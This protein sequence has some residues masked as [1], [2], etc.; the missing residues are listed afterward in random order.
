[1]TDDPGQPI[2]YK[3]RHRSDA[4]KAQPAARSKAQPAAGPVVQG[5][6]KQRGYLWFVAFFLVFLAVGFAL[7]FYARPIGKMV[8]EVYLSFKLKKSHL[9]GTEAAK[10]TKALTPLSTDPSKSVNTLLMGV[11]VGSGGATMTHCNSDTMMLICLQERDKKAVII[12]IPRDTMVQLPGHG[13]QKINAANMYYGPSGAIDAVKSLTGIDVNHYITMEFTGFEKVV[14]A[15]GGIPIHLNEPINDPNSGYL[16]AGDLNLDGWQALVLVRSRNMPMADIDRIGSQHAFMEA[17]MTKA[18][19]MKSILKANQIVDIVTSNCKTDY[20]AGQLMNLAE[21]LRGFK[22]KDVQMATVP[23][24]AQYVQGI[25]YWVANQPLVNQMA[26]QV[27]MSNWMSPDLLARFQAQ[28][29][30][31]AAVLNAPNADVITVLSGAGSSAPAASTV[32]QELT[33]MGHQEVLPG[34]AP[35]SP[36]T[37]VY[38]RSEAQANAQAILKAIPELAGAQIVQNQQVPT[39]YNSPVVIILG[40]N[41]ASPPLLATYGRLVTPAL[42]FPNLGQTFTSFSAQR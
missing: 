32:T 34:K 10:V 11:D 2:R 22:P 27:D 6:R 4:G 35:A 36:Q 12:S 24:A 7:G 20:S 14:N 30:T 33:L 29:H 41:F 23:G 15:L 42:D 25:S 3:G 28:A 37:I 40:S 16:P 8:G 31:R 9:S 5:A 26:S 21:E 39:T 1:M 18:A 19:S 13:T 17:L 38:F